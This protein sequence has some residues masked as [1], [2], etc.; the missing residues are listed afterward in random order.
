[1]DENRVKWQIDCDNSIRDK[2]FVILS[3]PTGSGK[4][5]RYENWAFNKKQ[6]P[7][8]ITAPIKALS[9]QRFRELRKEGYN[10]GLETGDIKYIPNNDCDIICCTQEIYN[11]K[12]KNYKNTTLV[13]DE[14]SYIFEEKERARTYID[15][16][17]YSEAENIM[18]CSATFG[19]SKKVKEYIDKITNKDFFLYENN[20]RLTPLTYEGEISKYSI[21]NSLVVAYT[22]QSCLDIAK[23][24]YNDRVERYQELVRKIPK[25][26]NLPKTINEKKI[27]ELAK[28]YNINNDK[29]LKYASM[30]VVYY[31]GSLYPKEKLFIEELF[32]QKLI[33]TVVGTDALALGVNF[34]IKNVVFAQLEKIRNSTKGVKRIEKNL[35][36]QLAGRAG[37]KG[38]Y[39]DGHV[40]Y[41]NDFFCE[42]DDYTKNRLS[43]L[44]NKEHFNKLVNSKNEDAKILLSPNI[45]DIL[46]GNKTIEEEA[47]FITEYSTEEKNYEEEKNNIT[48]IINYVSSFDVAYN[49]LKK[50]FYN[51]NF[52]NGFNNAIEICTPRV[53]RKIENLSNK[54]M[55][56]QPHFDKDIGMVYQIEYT[57]D[58]NCYVFVDILLETPI[59]ILIKKH[60]HSFYDLLILRKYM[61]NLPSKYLK[62]YDLNEIDDEINKLDHT[63]LKPYLF[64]EAKNIIQPEQLTIK[65]KRKT[66]NIYK[67]PSYFDIMEINGYKYIKLWKDDNII[68]ACNYPYDNDIDLCIFPKDITYK[69]SG[70]IKPSIGLDILKKINSNTINYKDLDDEYN[71]T[72][73]INQMKTALINKYNK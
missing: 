70:L 71:I 68:L 58:K 10:V 37:R 50:Q 61:Y 19:N 4:T 54:L 73:E 56:L 67:C 42:F 55:H 46:L 30:G 34:P 26:Y 25:K 48:D 44:D 31:Y 16:L 45:K 65:K 57:P 5:K 60:C 17:Y 6:K 51:L 72:E 23:A 40:Y 8:F 41:C 15:S 52:D 27:L 7:I 24:I 12:Y 59:N 29:L 1:M 28:E 9:N 14:F 38:F 18:I 33:D 62:N 53:K 47:L 3:S 21:R 39:D 2:N 32:E 49:Y 13:I 22:K 64:D 36:E 43:V 11:L 35:F 66:N 20:E 69:L 63:A